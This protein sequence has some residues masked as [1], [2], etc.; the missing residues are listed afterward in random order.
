MLRGEGLISF[1]DFVAV[2]GDGGAEFATGE[3]G[4]TAVGLFGRGVGEGG[5]VVGEPIVEEV[6]GEETGV[7]DGEEL[8]GELSGDV[9]GGVAFGGCGGVVA[10]LVFF[11]CLGSHGVWVSVV[12]SR[13]YALGTLFCD[14]HRGLDV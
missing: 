2:D 3:D 12:W 11:F 10:E 1:V 14:R 5:R 4:R 9:F 8:G 7:V 6:K 13:L